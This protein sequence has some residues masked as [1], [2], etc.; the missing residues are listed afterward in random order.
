[1][2]GGEGSSGAASGMDTAAFKGGCAYADL[3]NVD[4]PMEIWIPW[5]GFYDVENDRFKY[6]F[7]LMTDGHLQFAESILETSG[8]VKGIKWLK[9]NKQGVYRLFCRNVYQIYLGSK[10]KVDFVVYAAPEND[11]GKVKG[12]TRVAVDLARHLDIPTFNITKRE[13]LITLRTLTGYNADH[14]HLVKKTR[15]F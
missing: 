12:G 4:L 11:K 13:D 2:K 14:N 3:M 10:E 5:E 15:K 1:M 8:V 9:E 6:A 7:R